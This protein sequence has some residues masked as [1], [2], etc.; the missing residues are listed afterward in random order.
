MAPPEMQATWNYAQ[1]LVKAERDRLVNELTL[2][3]N[4]GNQDPG[5]KELILSK[6][7][8]N[9]GVDVLKELLVLVRPVGVAVHN[10]FSPSD[11]LMQPNF[12]GAVGAPPVVPVVNRA[13]MMPEEE[14]ILPIPVCNWGSKEVG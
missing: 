10:G 8:G 1:N 6:L 14:D 13:G 4:Q 2:I 11:V 7:Q 5:R 12:A 3:A 9:P